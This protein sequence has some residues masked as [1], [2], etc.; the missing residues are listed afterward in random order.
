MVFRGTEWHSSTGADAD[1]SGGAFAW[2]KTHWEHGPHQHYSSS[3]WCG[4]TVAQVK[5]ELKGRDDVHFTALHVRFPH[6][7]P[8]PGGSPAFP[9]GS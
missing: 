2:T 8:M 5:L 6:G 7:F 4:K 3:L 1:I 9:E